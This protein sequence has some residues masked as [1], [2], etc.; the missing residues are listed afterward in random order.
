MKIAQDILKILERCKIKGN[1]LYLPPGQLDRDVYIAVNK[2]LESIGGKWHRRTRGHVFDRD[3][4]EA[5]N[6][7]LLTGETTDMKKLFQFFP[8][9]RTVAEQICDLA[10][11]TVDS[12]VLEPSVGKG[13]IADVIWERGVSSLLGIELNQDMKHYL[14]GKPYASLVGVDFLE[15]AKEV[16]RGNI[17]AKFTHIITNPPFSK[18]REIEHIMAAFSLLA[19]GGILVSVVSHSP[20]W[21]TDT[22][23]TIFKDWLN[24]EDSFTYEEEIDLPEGAFKESGTMIPTKIIKLRREGLLSEKAVKAFV[25]TSNFALSS[26]SEPETK[27]QYSQKEIKPPTNKLMR[28]NYY[29]TKA[30]IRLECYADTVVVER[31]GKIPYITAVRLGGYPESVKGMAEAIFGGGS[32]TFNIDGEAHLLSSKLKQYRKE[33]SHDG[34]YA[35]AV[36]WINDEDHVQMESSDEDNDTYDDSSNDVSDSTSQPRKCYIFCSFEDKEQLFDELDKKTSVH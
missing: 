17:D 18:Q 11:L 13:G 2:C 34:L 8:T 16:K 3:P 20:F 5:F 1:I 26:V 21:R 4:A 6:D 24:S 30:E 22:K 9:P 36:L 10:E 33:Y 12:V 31:E 7:M 29:D 23:S 32:V 14:E 19:P 35:E 25:P 27:I 28:V 15:F